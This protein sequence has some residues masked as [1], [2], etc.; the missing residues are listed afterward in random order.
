MINKF[1]SVTK[2]RF[3]RTNFDAFLFFLIFSVIVWIFVQFSKEYTELVE[4][5]VNYINVPL[6]K[7][8][9]EDNPST[10]TLR[11]ENTGFKIAWFSLFP[12]TFTIDVSE[13]V[14]VGGKMLYNI[15]DH[16]LEIQEQ[17]DIDLEQSEFLVEEIA[18]DFDQLTEKMLPVLSRMKFEYAIGY[19]AGDSLQI[20]PD[21][22]R[23]S[24]PGN[25]LDTLSFLQTVPLEIKNISKDLSGKVALD[26]SLSN[27]TLYQREVAYELEVEKFTE[28]K[29]KVPVDIINVPQGA[30]VVI[31]PREVLLFF[32]VNLQDFKKVSASDF[33]VVVD[34]AQ[35]GED[36]NFLIPQIVEKPDFVT[37]LRLNENKIQFII[38]K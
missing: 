2:A 37:N 31:F 33:R 17:L 15:E 26:T 30:N 29:V 38:K 9:T 6:D 4:I 24:G 32:Q 12:P 10:L 22:V 8:I 20:R 34:F 5:P 13:G 21:S 35:A 3:R 1:R 14:E 23:V 36:Q 19:S 28:G 11:M 16:K 27:V 18:V 7:I 25:I